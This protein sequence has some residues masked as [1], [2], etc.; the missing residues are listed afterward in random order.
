MTSDRHVRRIVAADILSQ[1]KLAV[2][3]DA[4][5][6]KHRVAVDQTAKTVCGD[7]NF[8]P[9]L[10]NSEI[11]AVALVNKLQFNITFALGLAYNNG[12]FARPHFKLLGKK[13]CGKDF[14]IL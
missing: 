5:S 14:F 10:L 9:V 3:D 6:E 7:G 1:H 13:L 8:F 12:S 2:T 4:L 11:L